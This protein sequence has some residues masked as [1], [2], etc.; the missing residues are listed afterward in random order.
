[1]G[2]G[3]EVARSPHR[4]LGGDHR[5]DVAVEHL[6]KALHHD[7]PDSGMAL[8]QGSRPEQEDGPNQGVRQRWPD[9]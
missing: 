9:P 3:G 6:E 7:G 1:M 5:E 2:K 8:R 4:A